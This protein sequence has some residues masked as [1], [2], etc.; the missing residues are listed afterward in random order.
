MEQFA[1]RVFEHDCSPNRL[2]TRATATTVTTTTTTTTTRTQNCLTF[3]SLRRQSIYMRHSPNSP[4]HLRPGQILRR[5]VKCYCCM[6]RELILAD[7]LELHVQIYRYRSVTCASASGR[8]LIARALSLEQKELRLIG[9]R[10]PCVQFARL[11]LMTK[12]HEAPLPL[13][14]GRTK[15]YPLES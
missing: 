10:S 7:E 5:G 4:A 14:R 1:G 6:T 3:A 2:T 9:A 11:T 15:T 8:T 13:L 12:L